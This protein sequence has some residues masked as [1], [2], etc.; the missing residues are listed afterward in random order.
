VKK[1]KS[2]FGLLF[3]PFFYSLPDFNLSDFGI[4]AAIDPLEEVHRSGQRCTDL[5]PTVVAGLEGGGGLLVRR[6]SRQRADI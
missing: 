2:P 3:L 6:S 5:W 1:V 4:D